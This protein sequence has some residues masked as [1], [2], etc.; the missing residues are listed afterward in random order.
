SQLQDAETV[1]P[2]GIEEDPALSDSQK[3]SRRRSKTTDAV[4]SHG[5][6]SKMVE[7]GLLI[8]HANNK[9]RFLHPVLN[10]YLAGQAIGDNEADTTLLALPDWDGKMLSLR[11]LAARGDATAVADIMLRGSELPL[12]HSA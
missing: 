5:L 1:R 7:S 10:G 4:P 2:T 9:M 6:L 12:H 3:I 11:Y 8:S